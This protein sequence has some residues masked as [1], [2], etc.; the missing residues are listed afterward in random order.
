MTP[1][2]WR[3]HSIHGNIMIYVE[4]CKQLEKGKNYMQPTDHVTVHVHLIPDTCWIMG[5]LLCNFYD[6]FHYSILT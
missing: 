5:S 2:V 4:I 3:L 1:L 6:S